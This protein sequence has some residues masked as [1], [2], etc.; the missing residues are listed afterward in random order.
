MKDQKYK[1][2]ARRMVTFQDPQDQAIWLRGQLGASTQQLMLHSGETKNQ[3]E[4]RLRLLK[5]TLGLGVAVRQRWRNGQHPLFT[6]ILR[7]Y[8]A[9]LMADLKN[10]VI[11]QLAR[12]T[13]ETVDK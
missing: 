3:V 11:P 6:R 2:L 10:K 9:V 12:P 13:P 5:E 8:Q 1:K 7:D 4:Y